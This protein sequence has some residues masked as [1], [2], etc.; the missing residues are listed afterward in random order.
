MN[1]T[2]K[3]LIAV[4]VG[5]VGAYLYKRY[6]DKK[7][8]ASKKMADA[9]LEDAKPVEKVGELSRD[10]K[11][12]FIIEKVG[13]TPKE[14]ASGFEGTRFV[15]NP[16][17]GRM[18]PVGT[19]VEGQEPA[20]VDSVFLSAEG[21]VVAD[22]PKSVEI[23][24]KSLS[25]LSDDEIE[26]LYKVVKLQ[27]EKPSVSDNDAV[28]ELGVTNPK[29]LALFEMKLKKVLNDIKIMKK[30]KSFGDKW[31]IR[32]EKRKKRRQAI[33]EKLGINKSD[34][35]KVAKKVCGRRPTMSRS[36]LA[37]Y[38]KCVE[39][40]ANKMRSEI[41]SEVREAVATAPVSVKSEVSD[42][43]QSQFKKQV[44]GRREGGMFT[45][46]RWDGESNAYVENLVDKG[47]I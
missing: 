46:K 10:E 20:Y 5:V 25:E 36:K 18:Y 16:V 39:G 13:A 21:D 3:I 34:F 44:V 35:D 8:P 27:D 41:S 14:D 28:K 4:G 23:A 40:V 17:Y 11:E 32:K 12:E 33:K 6:R 42:E 7:A 29:A 19:I 1:K 26:L 24:E 45:G 47:L 2:Q 15:W 22:I 31:S 30:D 43:R 37:Q 38:K 9:K